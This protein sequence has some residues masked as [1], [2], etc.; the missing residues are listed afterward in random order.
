MSYSFQI[1]HPTVREIAK[2]GKGLDEFDHISLD[3]A[4]VEVFVKGLLNSGYRVGATDP[5]RREFLKDVGS[6]RIQ[7]AVYSTEIAFSIPYGDNSQNAIFEALQ[8]ASELADA[9]H[10][11]MFNPQDGDWVA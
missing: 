8:D 5:H 6:C 9:D 11:A 3:L 4:A 10:M 7:V 1:F 2:Q